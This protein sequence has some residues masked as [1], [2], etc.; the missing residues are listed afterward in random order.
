[1]KVDTDLCNGYRIVTEVNAL[2]ADFP[3]FIDRCENEQIFAN[4]GGIKVRRLTI[5]FYFTK[6]T[7]FSVE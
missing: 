4:K 1:M 2:L 7:L 5:F 3:S 6:Y